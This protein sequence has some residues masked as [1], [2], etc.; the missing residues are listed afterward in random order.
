MSRSLSSVRCA[1]LSP[2]SCVVTLESRV[3]RLEREGG[4][5]AYLRRAIIGD[6]L[7]R[8]RGWTAGVAGGTA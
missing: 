5:G 2:W 8:L 4:T 7:E 3:M 1:W 6:G